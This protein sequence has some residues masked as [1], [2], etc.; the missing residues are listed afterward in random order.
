V[1][2]AARALWIEVN[3]IANLQGL[4]A[5]AALLV[6]IHHVRVFVNGIHP[7]AFMTDVGACGVDIFFVISGFVMVYTNRDA[8]RT[9]TAFWRGRALRILPMYWLVT[10]AL[11]GLY[12]AGFRPVG[13]HGWS[14][15]DLG[16]SLLLIPNVRI[17]G[18]SEPILTLG[19]TLIYEAL[20]YAIFGLALLTRDIR[21]TVL[22]VTVLFVLLM[23]AGLTMPPES[24]AGRTYSSPLALEFA[25]GC[26]LG[27]AYVR[28]D[29]F[30]WPASARLAMP[31]MVMAAAAII[32]ADATARD[33]IL[34]D[35]WVRVLLT[36]LPA[37]AIVAGALAL[38]RSGR[39]LHSPFWLF[40]G[41]ASYALY[42]IHPLA[43]HASWKALAVVLPQDSPGVTTLMAIIAVAAAI[44]AG[45]VMHLT[46]E[47]PLTAWLA[48]FKPLRNSS[49]SA[50]SH[51]APV[52][53]RRQDSPLQR[54][55]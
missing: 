2:E 38:E 19:W 4:R 35:P 26:L 46:L 15:G 55:I 23:L 42:L 18:V 33:A 41:T 13:L 50:N 14:W 12:V 54:P 29:I 34:T 22:V 17:D 11:V 7:A 21:K 51:D 44:G 24:V 49:P 25:A 32:T 43:L 40:Q 47:R 16:A 1:V 20:F 27:L 53:V 5:L 37:T 10:C 9:P 8:Q 39:T 31:L 30:A 6:V 28:K 45:S 3:M 36:G 48:R 52:G